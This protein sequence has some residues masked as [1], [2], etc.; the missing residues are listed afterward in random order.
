MDRDKQQFDALFKLLPA[1]KAAAGL[2]MRIMDSVRKAAKKRER[3]AEIRQLAAISLASA[4]MVALAFVCVY[5]QLPEFSF[6]ST[7]F[8]GFGTSLKAQ[9]GDIYHRASSAIGD[10]FADLAEIFSGRFV[11]YAPFILI[12]CLLLTADHHLR[13]YAAK[14][15]KANNKQE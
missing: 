4:A 6:L 2:D 3:L 8:D 11:S 1:P 15:H 14:R 10:T 5:K 9:A 7:P 12:V 13:A